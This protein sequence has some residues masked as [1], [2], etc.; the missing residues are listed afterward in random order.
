MTTGLLTTQVGSLPKPDYL[1]RARSQ[2]ARGEL[3][4]EQLKELELR[5]TR[6]WVEFQDEIGIDVIVDGEQYRGDMVAFF[7][8]E[9][10]GFTRGGLVRSY[11]NR[12]YRKP[13]ITGPI[14]R[15]RA[16]TVEWWRYAQ[17]LTERPVK[18]MLTG[19][20]TIRDWSFDEHYPTRRDAVLDLARAI[21][22][23]ALA[24]QEAGARY[25]QI[26]EPA[27]STRMDELGLAIEALGIATEGLEVHTIT[28][29]CYGDFH[30]AYPRMLDLP[31]DQLDLEMTNSDFD[32]LERFEEH[33]FTKA[34]GL[35]VVDS[36]SHRIE[37]VDEVVKNVERALRL[38]PAERVYLDPDCGLKTRTVDE[39][40]DKLRVIVEA[41]R[42]V[43]STLG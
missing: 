15:R 22:E 11:G 1:L 23:E 30:N 27:V 24:L 31:V 42:R 29:I 37:D 38:I 9:L 14:R 21:R 20:Y 4:R 32:L 5:A 2:H 34:I 35:G 36:H 28:H 7:A 39:A 43:R 41:A 19:P 10:D 13:I 18:G 26:D 16:V 12:Y 25:I 6:E 3:S 33:P 17:S 8:E 40:K